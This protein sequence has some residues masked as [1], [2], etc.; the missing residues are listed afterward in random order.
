MRDQEISSK[1]LLA[2]AEGGTG[3]PGGDPAFSIT[4]AGPA[5]VRIWSKKK[6]PGKKEVKTPELTHSVESS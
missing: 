3:R 4:A 6:A 5:A 1:D 2:I